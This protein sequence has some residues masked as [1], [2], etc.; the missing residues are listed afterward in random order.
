MKNVIQFKRGF[1]NLPS[2]GNNNYQMAMSVASEL[3]QFGYILDQKAIEGLSSASSED[4][5]KLHNEVI[6]YLKV[7]TG[8]TRNFKPFWKGFPEQVM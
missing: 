2:S 4:I 6:N 3:M 8:S 1:I 5:I 7:A